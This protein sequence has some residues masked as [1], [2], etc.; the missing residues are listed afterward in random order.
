MTKMLETLVRTRLFRQAEDAREPGTGIRYPRGTRRLNHPRL[1]DGDVGARPSAGEGLAEPVVA[2]DSGVE[3]V[4]ERRQALDL[5]FDL[6]TQVQVDLTGLVE[7]PGPFLDAGRGPVLAH[8][9]QP[10]L[11]AEDVADLVQVEAEQVLQLPD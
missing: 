10:V 4:P 3:F 8:P 5:A 7:Q 6:G 2:G 9:G 11:M 1:H